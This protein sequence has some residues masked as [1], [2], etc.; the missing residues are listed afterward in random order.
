M[1][2]E[3]IILEGIYNGFPIK[4]WVHSEPAKWK[5]SVELRYPEKLMVGFQIY[6]EAAIHTAIK[7]FG[8]QDLKAGH[9]AFDDAFIVKAKNAQVAKAKMTNDFCD[10]MVGLDKNTSA[11]ELNDEKMTIT[12]DQVLGDLKNLTRFINAMGSAMAKLR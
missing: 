5:T 7:I 1:D 11:I 10:Q 8:F 2:A 9:K 12:V 6:P 3:A 4:A